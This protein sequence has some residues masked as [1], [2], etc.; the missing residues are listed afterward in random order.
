MTT[1]TTRS[2][3]VHLEEDAN[4][5][6]LPWRRMAWVTWRQHRVALVGLAILLGAL[7]VYLWLQGRQIHHAYG[8]AIACHPASSGAC[9]NALNYFTSTYNLTAR[10]IPPLL[11][12]GVPALIGA[13]LGPPY[14]PAS[15]RRAPFATPGPRASGGGAGRSPS[16]CRSQLLPRL[17]LSC[18]AFCSPGITSPFS[19][20]VRPT[21]SLPPLSICAESRSPSGRWPP[22][23]SAASPVC[24]SVA[25]CL[26]S[27]PP[28]PHMP[29]SFWWSGCSCVST[30]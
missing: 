30:T 12:Q 3:S 29:G 11:L 1:L 24:S 9:V 21:R 20:T 28:W 5:L 10:K 27:L 23:P 17:S 26:R 25:S 14:W 4:L 7:A 16:S 22:S 13:F 8:I 18:S 6:P 15:W 2:V 19:L